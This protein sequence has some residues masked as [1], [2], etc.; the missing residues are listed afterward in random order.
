MRQPPLR[1]RRKI[2]THRLNLKCPHVGW[3][4][5]TNKHVR[6]R[7]HDFYDLSQS[8]SG[9]DIDHGP[10]PKITFRCRGFTREIL[11]GHSAV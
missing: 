7:L 10:R 6:T 11:H 2:N 3:H 8:L 9:S 1:Y 4:C 5:L